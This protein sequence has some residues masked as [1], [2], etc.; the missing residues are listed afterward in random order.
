MAVGLSAVRVC[1]NRSSLVL[2]AEL[3]AVADPAS[4]GEVDAPVIIGAPE[5]ET[6]EGEGETG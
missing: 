1:S 4:G 5:A 2:E 6:Y 3:P